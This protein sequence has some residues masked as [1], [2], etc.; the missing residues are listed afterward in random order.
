MITTFLIF[1]KFPITY[2]S[3]K[4]MNAIVLAGGYAT[5]MWPITRRR[6]K[7]F[8]PF[9]DQRLIDLTLTQLES[10]DRIETVYIATNETFADEFA[11][12]LESQSY[13]K[14]TL[15]IEETCS[16]PEKPGVI[17]ALDQLVDRESITD[18][19]LVVAGDN[20]LDFALADFVDHFTARG[21]PTVAAYDIDDPDR[22]TPYGVIECDH[23]QVTDFRE[24]PP[25]PSSSLISTGCYAFPAG[26]LDRLST[27]LS[28]GNNPDEPGWFLQWLHSREPLHAFTFDGTWFDIDTPESYLYAIAETLDGD[29]TIDPSATVE[30]CHIGD[31]VHVMD[32]A[33]LVDATIEQSV[34][35]PGAQIRESAVSNSV[36]DENA[37]IDGVD[38]DN[39][40]VASHTKIRS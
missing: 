26:T 19:T 40:V 21:D 12:H 35:F 17:G 25:S 24:K 8:L 32:D 11:A 10:E 2:Q 22:A 27:Y 6:P 9:D 38:I 1:T 18:D 15:S 16:E 5:R 30:N 37:V 39:G 20:Y 14:P 3:S 31:N 23:D 7:M 36:L 34:V 4:A 33:E 28:A 29:A 13:E